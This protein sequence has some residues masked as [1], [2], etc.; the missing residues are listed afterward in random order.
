MPAGAKRGIGIAIIVQKNAIDEDAL[1]RYGDVLQYWEAVEARCDALG[2][3]RQFKGLNVGK[4][5]LGRK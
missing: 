5:K 1:W 2:V 3:A 4:G